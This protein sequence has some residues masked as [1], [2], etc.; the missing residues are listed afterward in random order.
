MG[1]SSSINKV[2]KEY[3]VI[4]GLP[5]LGEYILLD[6]LSEIKLISNGI[7]FLGVCKKTHQLMIHSRFIKIMESLSFPIA[8]I[9]KDPN[10]VEF[11]DIDGVQKKIN[12]LKNDTSTISLVQVLDN[13]IWSLEVMFQNTLGY[14]RAIGIVRDSYD[15][16]AKAHFANKPHTDHIATF[17]GRWDGYPV[18]YKGQGTNG[19]DKFKDNQILR[20]EFDSF[21]G[22]L[23]LFIGNVQQPVYFSGIREKV[24]FI[25]YLSRAETSCI[26][27]SLKQLITPTSKQIANEVAVE[28]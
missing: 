20:L 6:V 3:N 5:G 2:P 24:R 25:V 26:I 18:Y 13:G 23:I 19:N 17:D 27:R 21:N 8:I 14:Y 9:N 12:Q 11:I 16:P 28:W 10:Y 22:T 4:G 1:Q 15:I 7:Q